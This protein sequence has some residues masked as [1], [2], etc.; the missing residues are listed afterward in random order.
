MHTE[1][2]ELI[3]LRAVEHARMEEYDKALSC[4]QMIIDAE[5][6]DDTAWYNKAYTL[7]LAGK[8][9]ES[10]DLYLQ[11]LE[12][13][14]E[15]SDI[16]LQLGYIADETGNKE[17]AE[18]HFS[19]SI[20]TD[21]LNPIPRIELGKLLFQEEAYEKARICFT[22]AI[23]FDP[24]NAVIRDYLG[25]IAQ[26]TGVPEEA[27]RWFLESVELDPD[28]EESWYH[29]A[30]LYE[31]MGR[32]DEE[33][34]CYDRLIQ[35]NPE[36]IVPWLKKGLIYL[37]L[38]ELHQS[39]RCF[40]IAARL[41]D[42]SHLPFLLRGLVHLVLEDYEEASESLGHAVS[43]TGEPDIRLQYARSLI[44]CGRFEE[45]LDEYQEVMLARPEDQ[46]ARE[47][48]IRALYSLK[49]WKEVVNHCEAQRES[50]P[51]PLWYILEGR[52]LGWYLGNTVQAV[53][54]L[55][56]GYIITQDE[57]ILLVLADLF[58]HLERQPEALELLE[59][60]AEKNPKPSILYRLASLLGQCTRYAEA[61]DYFEEILTLQPDDPDI[62]YLTGQA[63]ELAGDPER[64]LS[65]YTQ[66][67]TKIPDS[68]DIWLSRARVLL[69]L[70]HYE[71]AALNAAQVV[72]LEPDEYD[73][74]LLKGMAERSAGLFD[75]A[76]VSFTAATTLDADNPDG[77]QY[78]GEVLLQAGEGRAAVIAYSRGIA[79]DPASFLS[80]LGKAEA[81]EYLHEDASA[82]ETYQEILE[83]FGPSFQALYG[84][85]TALLTMGMHDEGRAVLLT[86]L[87]F[88]AND[89]DNLRL[90]FT[91]FNRI[92][93]PEYMLPSIEEAVCEYP[94]NGGLW[95]L[96]GEL[97]QKVG[98]FSEAAV[99]YERAL[100]LDPDDNTARYGIRYC[101]DQMP[102]GHCD[103]SG[104]QPI[105][106]E[107]Q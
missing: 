96:K 63:H 73:A 16:C 98:H 49:K 38:D 25:L 56:D 84:K 27:E 72:D 45:A 7:R 82:L 43:I 48:Y 58:V 21:P 46:D 107:N 61:A 64:A 106:G 44:N 86:A 13:N 81:F 68:P 94:D 99:C 59:V 105:S 3:M 51:N 53:Q 50:D 95:C 76:R 47:G 74:W 104:K 29:L 69:E 57:Q 54:I 11:L 34:R 14:P 15:N 71:S 66:V 17:Q 19:H 36:Q 4:I 23:V 30:R 97:Y 88:A 85:G 101:K 1:E 24:E 60:L 20:E 80:Y 40:R 37:L 42:A 8:R 79:A 28:D 18:E 39:I 31:Q 26:K 83:T 92:K 62:A 103:E 12:D 65:L 10:Y 102:D 5:P 91:A 6:D 77:W 67:I 100:A 41:D 52:A 87:A 55:R 90:L 89:P 2:K 93:S 78:L 22:D 32:R 9:E 75:Q 35:I 33:I 70:G